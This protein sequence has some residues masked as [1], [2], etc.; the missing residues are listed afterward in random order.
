MPTHLY[1]AA[2]RSLLLILAFVLAQAGSLVA[3]EFS[4]S[5]F[6]PA[7][8]FV[9]PAVPEENAPVDLATSPTDINAVTTEP[10]LPASPAPVA[11]VTPFVIT[12][13]P[14]KP[15]Q[16]PFWDRENRI[17]FAVAGALAAAD[18]CAT[19]A[20]LA[21]GGK[22][23]NPVTRMFSGSTPALATNFALETGG[24]MAISYLFHRTGHHKLERIASF[25]NIGG[26][27]AAVAYSFAHR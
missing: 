5:T 20:N 24:T 11:P 12:V 7:S 13:P 27:A 2:L 22:E 25:V 1:R 4:S 8:A 18:F 19:R 6:P 9:R 21:S 23:L 14:R 15:G 3:Q 16:H 26:S 10:M 17:L